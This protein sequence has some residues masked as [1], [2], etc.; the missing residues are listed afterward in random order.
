MLCTDPPHTAPYTLHSFLAPLL[1]CAVRSLHKDA[2]ERSA[3]VFEQAVRD[4]AK[5]NVITYSSLLSAL[6]RSR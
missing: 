3:L 1:Q 2:E 6:S 5:P 4:G